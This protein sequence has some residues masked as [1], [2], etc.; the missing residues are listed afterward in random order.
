MKTLI[1]G[2]TGTLARPVIEHLEKKGEKLRLFSRSIDPAQFQGKHEIYKG[3]VFSGQDLGA[4]ME[5]CEAIHISLSK[6][7]EAE[8][9]K[10]IVETAIDKKIRLITYISGCTVSEENRWFP[11]IDRKYRAE[12]SIIQSGIPYMIFRPTWFFESLEMMVRNGKAMMIG[13]QPHP[14]RWIA[15]DDLGRMVAR[16]YSLPEARNKVF[17]VL[18]PEKYLM[19]DLMERYI[20][21][22]HL[23]IKKVSYISLGMMKIIGTLTGKKPMKEVASMFGYF[24]K[25]K[26]PE[27]GKETDKLLGKAEIDF[28]LWLKS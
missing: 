16:A 6:V 15:G 9:V 14:Y 11:M 20:R 5:G 2:A 13:K 28:E 24:E 3:D 17:F 26:E 4:A 8:A 22:K 18:G 19:G 23:E 21:E 7:D 1:L 12:Q 10:V 25:V 27:N